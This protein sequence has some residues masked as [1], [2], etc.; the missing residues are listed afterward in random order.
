MGP[1]SSPWV[2]ETSE[3]KEQISNSNYRAES[4]HA[5]CYRVQEAEFRRPRD[6]FHLQLVTAYKN[7]TSASFQFDINL[8]V[9]P[10][11]LA[12]NVVV[13]FRH[14]HLALEY[15]LVSSILPGP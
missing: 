4:S 5:G 6:G 1:T 7:P 2:A 14:L 3:L 8:H 13:G 9:M 11:G 10:F 12:R 15:M